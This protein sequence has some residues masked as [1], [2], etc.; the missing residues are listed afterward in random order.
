MGGSASQLRGEQLLEYQELTFLTKQEILQA[1]RRF[2]ELLGKKAAPYHTNADLLTSRVST[3]TL[4]EIPELKANPFRSRVCLVF[5]S[6]ESQGLSFE[7]FLDML[8]A[9]S[10]SASVEVKA[11]YAFRVFDFDGDG[12]LGKNDLKCLVNCL[13]G[14]ENNLNDDDM[15]LLIKNI[16]AESDIDQDGTVN[17][18]E[19]QHVITKSPDFASS[20]KITL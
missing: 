16:L 11:H 18:S 9:L 1:E 15:E 12:T 7:D 10:D 6:D 8:S 3:E 19:F 20:F 2:L 4:C 17:L 5:S 13:T 14:E